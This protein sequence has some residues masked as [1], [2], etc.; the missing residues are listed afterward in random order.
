MTLNHGD[1]EVSVDGN[2][3]IVELKGSFNEYGAKALTEQI[4]ATI[5]TFAGVPFSI[6]VNDLA[7]EGITPEAYEQL[8]NYNSWLNGQNMRA[9]AMIV[10]MLSLIHI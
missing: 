7:L 8:N 4:K 2:I 3:I 5:E 6:A 9:K 10:A 1:F